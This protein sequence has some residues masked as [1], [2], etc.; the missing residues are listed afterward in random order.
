MLGMH[1]LAFGTWVIVKIVIWGVFA[2]SI[3]VIKRK[4]DLGK[5]MWVA[6]LL[7]A[8]VA[9]YLGLQ[10]HASKAG[11]EIPSEQNQNQE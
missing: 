6:L 10:P 1:K 8:A 5:V 7:L 2:F 11:A 9:A 3:V 4:P